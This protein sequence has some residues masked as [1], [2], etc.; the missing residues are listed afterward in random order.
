MKY[1]VEQLQIVPGAHTLIA[2]LTGA[3]GVS[4]RHPLT[5]PAD[6]LN[7]EVPRR[8]EHTGVGPNSDRCV[9]LAFITSGGVKGGAH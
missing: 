6:R 8:I 3:S 4:R 5:E 7:F 2:C 1:L 9:D